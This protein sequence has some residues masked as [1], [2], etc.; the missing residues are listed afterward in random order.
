MHFRSLASALLLAA[1]ALPAAA[2]TPWYVSGSAGGYWRE[3]QSGPA[4]ITNGIVTAPGTIH[5]SFDPGPVLNAAV[6]YRLPAGFRVEGEIGYAHYSAHAIVPVSSA[7]PTLDGRTFNRR[8]GGDFNRY[9]A[10]V[11]AFYDLPLTA[12]LTPYLGAGIGFAHAD[13]TRT[14]FASASGAQFLQGGTS[15]DHGVMLAEGGV[16]IAVAPS[17]SL[18]PAYRYVRYFATG[19]RT[20][21]E[22]AH[23]VKLG[24]RYAF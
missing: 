2:Q 17:W 16:A 20:G 15:R 4:T 23:V 8:S 11:N 24:L 14:V 10:T 12:T 5:E 21:D 19:N 7:F 22:S 9:T 18:V 1:S 6:G 13:N 3:D